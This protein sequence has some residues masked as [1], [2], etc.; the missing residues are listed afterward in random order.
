VTAVGGLFFPQ[1]EALGLDARE[2]TP[3]LVQ[4]IAYAT[5]ETRSFARAAIVL[6]EVGGCPV[7]AK[8]IHRV[9]PA[10][11][12]ELAQQQARLPTSE[13]RPTEPPALA[14]VYCD[15]GRIRTRRAERGPGVH[16][17]AWRET[18]NACLLRMTHRTFDEDPHPD[19]PA[20]FRD[21]QKVA[22][23]AELAEN[24][25][26]D[27]APGQELPAAD[28]PSESGPDGRAAW[29]P[30]RLV[31]SCVS[32][33]AEVEQ[34]GP[35]V[36][37]EARRRHFFAAEHR[38]FLGDG[39][40]WNWSLW[41]RHFPDFVP[42]LDFIHP[43]SYLFRA[44]LVLAGQDRGLAWSYYLKLAT[45]CWQGRVD[46]VR[47]ALHEWL[48]REVPDPA[49][50]AEQDPRQA[51]VAAARYLEHQHARMDYARYRRL[52][53]PVTTAHMESLV[54]EINYR[55]KGTEMFWNDPDGAEAI[56]QLRAAA[57]CDDDRLAHYLTRRPGSP[58]LRRPH[59]HTAA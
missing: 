57:L 8:T 50:L 46:D 37:R 22:Q 19:L 25:A 9:A 5:A 44:A 42:I 48:A 28:P 49:A 23:W 29:P 20:A 4:R 45:A 24:S 2:L 56:L 34:F 27:E 16:D 41:Q 11:G 17:P 18:K 39:L 31:R 1:R 30:Q 13:V 14:A 52:G 54:K 6:K 7:S 43:L 3:G 55:V 12:R 33:L 36:A 53:L 15:G 26:A 58:Y 40:A 38:A 35:Q 21:P 10:V 51:V 47:A 59:L 32:S